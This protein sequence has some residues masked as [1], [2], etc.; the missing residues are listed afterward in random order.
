MV[1]GPAGGGGVFPDGGATDD[2]P[3][4]PPHA[5]TRHNNAAE[6]AARRAKRRDMDDPLNRRRS[7]HKAR[8][9]SRRTFYVSTLVRKMRRSTVSMRHFSARI[10][11]APE[12]DAR[13]AALLGAVCTY[14]GDTL[15][16]WC[17]DSRA[18]HTRCRRLATSA[19]RCCA[20]RQ[21]LVADC[22]FQRRRSTQGLQTPSAPLSRAAIR[23]PAG[24]AQKWW[25]TLAVDPPTST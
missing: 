17:S 23:M 19:E 4:P 21:L 14:F 5:A 15:A 24:I 20:L 22:L 3:P 25:G 1:S 6:A 2:E 10:D 7:P 13:P 11:C 18:R 16:P 9:S 12:C 8:V